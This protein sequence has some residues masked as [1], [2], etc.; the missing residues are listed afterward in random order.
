MATS[1]S[2]SFP[3]IGE[4]KSTA[5]D[6]ICTIQKLDGRLYLVDS[7]FHNFKMSY[8][9]FVGDNIKKLCARNKIFR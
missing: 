2:V 3:P 4:K 5:F 6:T 9:D 7:T 8:S 1:S